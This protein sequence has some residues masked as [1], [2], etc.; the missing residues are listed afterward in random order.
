MKF[1]PMMKIMDEQE[2][3]VENFFR[4]S[5]ENDEDLIYFK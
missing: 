1:L 3:L 5:T 2:N 4:G